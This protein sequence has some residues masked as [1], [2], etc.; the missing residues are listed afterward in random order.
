MYLVISHRKTSNIC[1]FY[2][3]L[4]IMFNPRVIMACTTPPAWGWRLKIL[5]KSL[6]GGS[7]IFILVV[8]VGGRGRWEG[9]VIL[10]QKLKLHNP[11]IHFSKYTTLRFLVFPFFIFQ[12]LQMLLFFQ[13]Y[14]SNILINIIISNLM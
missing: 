6:L 13:Y 11:L 5:E 4:I 1:P 14:S 10:K 2:I 12:V 9:H 3:C 8:V 7:E